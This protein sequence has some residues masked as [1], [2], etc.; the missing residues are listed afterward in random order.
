MFGVYCV[1]IVALRALVFL[2]GVHVG[3]VSRTRLH[4]FCA[5]FFVCVP[6]GRSGALVFSSLFFFFFFSFFLFFS[7]LLPLSFYSA[8]ASNL[9]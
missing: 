1:A 6:V 5:G 8:S 7:S 9:E 2:L 4:A 3:W